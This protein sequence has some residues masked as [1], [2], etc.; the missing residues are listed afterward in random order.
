MYGQLIKKNTKFRK[1]DISMLN[2]EKICKYDKMS[3]LEVN[4]KER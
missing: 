1:G 2:Y 4:L 3:L